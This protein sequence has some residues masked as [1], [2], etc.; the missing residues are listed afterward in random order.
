M[1]GRTDDM[2]KVKGVNIFPGQIDELLRD[3][4]G[5]SSEYQVMIDHLYGKD[6]MTLFFEAEPGVDK[7]ALSGEV[8]QRF[9]A[10]VGL[11]V[12]AKAVGIGDLPR[13]EKKSTRIFDNRY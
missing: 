6:I 1:I 2:I 5:A 13:S 10:K 7:A 3:I 4:D 8:V 9:K 11:T 12:V